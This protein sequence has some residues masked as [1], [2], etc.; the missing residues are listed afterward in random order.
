MKKNLLIVGTLSATDEKSRSRSRKSVVRI[1]IRTK[2]SRIHNIE[3]SFATNGTGTSF[4]LEA[5]ETC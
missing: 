4:Q 1:R 2:M 5:W 3:H